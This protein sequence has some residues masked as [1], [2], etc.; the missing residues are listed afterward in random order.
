FLNGT[1]CRRRDITD[2][3]LGTGLG[4]RSYAIIEQGMISK[5][6]EAKPEDLRTTLEEAAG[7]SK[8]KE[9][10][11][12]TENRMR[13][14]KENLNRINDIC[15]EL[16]KQLEK[17]QRQARTA[18]KYK[19][20]KQEE[21]K[22]KGELLALQ[23][24]EIDNESRTKDLSVSKYETELE[25]IVATQRSFETGIEQHR[26]T[27]IETTDIFNEVQANFYQIGSDIATK[28]Q[29]I[30]HIKSRRSELEQDLRQIQKELQE[31]GIHQSTDQSRLNELNA[32]I[33]DVEPR[34]EEAKERA[35]ISEL[36]LEE[37]EEQQNA[38]QS[39]WDSFTH[40]A[41]E[42][43][44]IAEVERT[45]VG[46]MED[47]SRQL[48][49][50]HKRL[51]DEFASLDSETLEAEIEELSL[52]LE[53]VQA[54]VETLKEN[55]QNCQS[56]ISEVRHQNSEATNQLAAKRSDM[57]KTS[58]RI[59]SLEAL[60]EAA[61]G[62][63]T[64]GDSQL[65]N[66]LS[67]RRL[68]D[69]P[70][71]AQGIK[72]QDGWE[73]AIET[74][75]G[76]H[77]E[78][79]C[80][81][82]LSSIA[83]GIDGLDENIEFITRE[84]VENEVHSTSHSLTLLSDKVETQW[85]ISSFMNGVYCAENI[86]QAI[87]SRPS[88]GNGESIVTPEGA[89]FGQNW[90]RVNKGKDDHAG[91]LQREKDLV[92]LHNEVEQIT[93]NVE[94]LEEAQELGK[95]KLQQLEMQRDEIQSQLSTEER[96]RNEVK[97]QNAAKQMRIDQIMSRR[98]RIQ[99]EMSELKSQLET[100]QQLS[101]EARG[102]LEIAMEAMDEVTEKRELLLSRRDDVRNLVNETRI[103]AM[104]EGKQAHALQLEYQS[105]RSSL[106]ATEQNLSRVDQQLKSLTDRNTQINQMLNSDENPLE[107]LSEDLEVL[108]AQRVEVEAQLNE[109]RQQVESIDA[110]MR[111]LSNK[112][113]D[114]ELSVE[115]ARSS[116]EKSRMDGQALKVRRQT[117]QEQLVNAGYELD[118]ILE[119]LGEECKPKEW[120][121]SIEQLAQKIQRLGAINLAAID[122]YKEQSER[123]VYLDSQVADLNEALET[124]ENAIRKIDKETRVKFK[125][126][127]DFVNQ[128]MKELF[129]KL[130]GGGHA[131]LEMTG[132]DLL[133]TGI[134]ILARPPGKRVTNIH[135]LSGGEKALTAV[136]MVFAIFQLNPAPFCMLDEV[137]APLDEANVGRFSNMVK[138]MSEHLQFIFIS[139]NKT[140][141][142]IADHLNGVTMHEPGVSRMVS[143]DVEE[144]AELAVM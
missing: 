88:L 97:S 108:L 3:F 105:S 24:R 90:L 73:K 86:A 18:E 71:L 66:W 52:Q 53:E 118:L 126:T 58:G 15:E 82:D 12:E 61:M 27:H 16:D 117:I 104:G 70:R 120:E 102:R 38:W 135:L 30:Q 114:A 134:A 89:W 83:G 68:S 113:S 77:L 22:L 29:N 8:Y 125:E 62:K 1:K 93:E 28:E 4:P 14:T 127:F 51:L 44:K 78:A 112:R 133:D 96:R 26:E 136:A 131:Y 25:A 42:P 116:L 138:E 7:I 39:E 101:Q 128:G 94:E 80:V 139:H 109:V 59:A 119:D 72:V 99:R 87:Q 122:E 23:W 121:K 79:V 74:V 20:L 46:H 85:P 6:I 35:E 60:Q 43:A 45:R 40:L 67:E 123:K 57:H 17:L 9:R 103:A 137:D 69:A 55:Q 84:S 115:N 65:S 41:G 33:A 54:V 111:N 13:N 37:A 49:S 19:T 36:Q 2:I 143:V 91:M 21:R 5:L 142:E 110:E 76:F 11:R 31:A 144:A 124:L 50:R 140:T 98:E 81:D 95:E 47:Q 106:T 63:G 34:L 64:K 130:F 129:P 92:A 32:K 56:D 141:M 48:E 100:N 132:D 10:R 75:L 107:A